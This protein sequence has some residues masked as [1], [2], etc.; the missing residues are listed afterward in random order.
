MSRSDGRGS[1]SEFWDAGKVVTKK[2]G[3]VPGLRVLL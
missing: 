2:A 1:H 3:L